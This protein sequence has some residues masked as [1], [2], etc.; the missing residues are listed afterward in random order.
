MTSTPPMRNPGDEAPPGSE[1]TGEIS[2]PVCHGSGQSAERT[3]CTHCGGTGMV[4]VTVGD[5]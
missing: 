1:Q 2:C 3:P 5:A 4:V